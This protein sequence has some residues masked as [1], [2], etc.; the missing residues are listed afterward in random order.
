MSGQRVHWAHRPETFLFAAGVGVIG[1]LVG[2]S[3]Q[4]IRSFIQR[5]MVGEGSLIEA[6]KELHWWQALLIPFL[7]ASAASLLMYGLMRKY[8]RQGMADVM[9]SVTLK[10]ARKLSVR[11]TIA[12]ALASLL[13][14]STGG[15]LGREGPIAYLSAS[16]GAR[17][18]RLSRMPSTR[19]GL[20]AGCGIAAGMSAAYFAPFGAAIFAM[21]VVLGNFSM[22]ILAPVVVSTVVSSLVVA[23][24]ATDALLG[25]WGV[26][27]GPLFELPTFKQHHASEYL[28]YIALGIAAAGA[29]WLFI[30]ILRGTEGA[31]A[32]TR[33]PLLWSL[34]L[35]GLLIGAIGIWLP[36]VWGN[37]Y[38]A[39]TWIFDQPLGSI[40]GLV[41]V[42]FVMKMVGTSITLGSGGKGGVFTPTMFIGAALG[43][44]V[45][46]AAQEIFATMDMTVEPKHYAVLGMAA[47]LA[48]TTHAPM[49][50]IFMLFEMTRETEII[51]PTMVAAITASVFSRAIG[52]ES[53]YVYALRK[54]GTYLP[55]GIEETTLTT[56]TVQDLLRRDAVWIHESATFDM[57]VGMVQKTRTDSIYV[58]DQNTSLLGAIRLHDIKNFLSDA[59]LGPAVIAADLSIET[60]PAT[61]RQT[62]AEIVER[63]DDPEMHEIPVVD[64]DDGTL[65]GTVDRRDVISALSVEVLHSGGLRAKFVE[66]AGAQHYVEMPRDHGVARLDVPSDMVGK[67]FKDCDFRKRTGLTVLTIVRPQDGSEIRILPEPDTVLEED[68]GLVVM[69]PVKAIEKM[70]GVI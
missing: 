48:A 5:H 68:D 31:F 49:T 25:D 70:G 43:L 58:V 44:M 34:P 37:G 67:A 29:A 65:L 14:I 47:V 27:A 18:A 9:E 50:A 11:R 60:R 64:P 46:A 61:P 26:R 30:R 21:E 57:I 56:T 23:G 8:K 52:L 51:L 2:T 10:Q 69:G 20:F 32:R 59:D 62:L 28:V 53:I 16:L 19:L 45:G 6:A 22:E 66:H 3:F 40:L 15:S 12:P 35:G 63:F 17:F 1:G 4:L 41:A 33:M 13:I 55:E 42:L 24:L 54:R 38:S 7:G 36:E 39:I